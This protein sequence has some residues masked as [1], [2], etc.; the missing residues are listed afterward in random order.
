MVDPKMIQWRRWE[1]Q[2]FEESRQSRKPILL[3]ISA[4]WCHWCHQMDKDN[5]EDPETA[6]LINERYIPV[7]VDADRRPDVN[8]RYNQGGWPS[9][10][11]LDTQG[12]V[13]TGATYVPPATFRN[14]LRQVS[15]EFSSGIVRAEQISG[16]ET[17]VEEA[18]PEGKLEDVVA[19]ELSIIS[20]SFDDMFGGFGNAPKFP[21]PDAVE[22]ALLAWRKT[23]KTEYELVARKTLDGMINI[24]DKED[25][26]FFRYATRRE[27]VAP[28]YEKLLETNA[29]LLRLYSLAFSVTENREY[30]ETAK[31]T[32]RFIEDWLFDKQFWASMDADEEYYQSDDRERMPPPS[33][34][35]VAFADLNG[36]AACCFLDASVWLG[37]SQLERHAYTTLDNCLQSLVSSDGKVAHFSGESPSGML[38]DQAWLSLACLRAFEQNAPQKTLYLNSA[39][40]IIGWALANLSGDR[41]F[42]GD[43]GLEIS[44]ER[45]KPMDDNA[46][47]CNALLKLAHIDGREELVGKAE[48]AL[49][50]FSGSFTLYGPHAASYALAVYQLRNSFDVTLVDVGGQEKSLLREALRLFEPAKTIVPLNMKDDMVAARGYPQK[51]ACYVCG[52]GLCL[53]AGDGPELQQHAAKLAKLDLP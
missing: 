51:A 41:A 3:S 49:R 43:L 9:T 38:A 5:Y 31:G 20:R 13:I 28:H 45:T 15:Q 30:E 25:G 46:A 4:T 29:Q 7:R 33:V 35:K 48:N 14:A 47:F 23:G 34:D 53:T 44:G 39:R 10:V 26:G 36:I 19:R 42:Y 1:R 32:A 18:K 17:R 6:A 24:F 21:A 22:L 12:E 52:S 50:E 37:N 27:W 11:F 40:R 16:P 2:A 8:E